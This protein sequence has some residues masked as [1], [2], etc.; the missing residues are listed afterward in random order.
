MGVPVHNGTSV[1]MIDFLA[2][3]QTDYW[4]ESIGR[5]LR[6]Y[7][8]E[9]M[10]NYMPQWWMPKS[11]LKDAIQIIK[12]FAPNPEVALHRMGQ[13]V[14]LQQ[15]VSGDRVRLAKPLNHLPKKFGRTTALVSAGIGRRMLKNLSLT[16]NE[17]E[18]RHKHLAYCTLEQTGLDKV[19]LTLNGFDSLVPTYLQFDHP[20][21]VAV[22][23]MRLYPDRMAVQ[24]FRFGN[25]KKIHWCQAIVPFKA[26]LTPDPEKVYLQSDTDGIEYRQT[27]LPN[28]QDRFNAVQ[29]IRRFK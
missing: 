13:I 11:G 25:A 21:F 24:G 22:N 12:T 20:K 16:Y 3:G 26:H 10:D 9:H 27:S 28:Y 29:I 19:G 15:N 18:I 5:A 4:H 17:I 14:D 23:L 1:T 7:R 6:V 2:T 8:A